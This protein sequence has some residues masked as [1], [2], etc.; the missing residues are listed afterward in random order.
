MP[1][2]NP[3][4]VCWEG[5]PREGG[6]QKG[7][8]ERP[9]EKGPGEGAFVPQ[10]ERGLHEAPLCE[11]PSCVVMAFMTQKERGGGE[12]E[13]GRKW[14]AYT[15][16]G[17]GLEVEPV[18]AASETARRVLHPPRSLDH[19]GEWDGGLGHSI[20]YAHLLDGHRE[21]KRSARQ[22]NCRQG[23]RIAESS[24]RQ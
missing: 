16:G 15:E 13:G 6:A 20:L 8:Q 9:P 1:S 3:V 11:R 12:R 23:R 7:P 18:D 5:P 10:K 2:L 4:S 17:G 22:R 14:E 24:H 21:Q 19:S